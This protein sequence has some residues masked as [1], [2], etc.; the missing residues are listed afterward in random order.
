M[1]R[2]LC[3]FP[4]RC[5]FGANIVWGVEPTR[6]R[7]D[8]RSINPAHVASS[9][10]FGALARTDRSS[11]EP[12][13]KAVCAGT[14]LRSTVFK[15]CEWRISARRGPG[16]QMGQALSEPVIAGWLNVKGVGE[17]LRE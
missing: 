15:H 16:M 10:M 13:I 2:R 5:S 7:S 1:S 11:V 6:G 17:S 9:V 12:Q 8:H 4:I 14:H 3:L